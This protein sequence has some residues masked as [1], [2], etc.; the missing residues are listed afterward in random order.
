[1]QQPHEAGLL[2]LDISKAEQVLDWMP[3]LNS[4]QAIEWTMN[5]YRKPAG[6]KLDYTL[7]QIKN[8]GRL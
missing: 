2:K 1:M 8:Y 6:Q 5:W 3:R 7:E 4:R